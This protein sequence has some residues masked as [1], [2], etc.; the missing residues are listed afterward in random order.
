MVH[1][2]R[3]S[4]GSV[5]VYAVHARKERLKDDALVCSRRRRPIR[6]GVLKEILITD[7]D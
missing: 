4:A 5:C 7:G 2:Y 3:H 6:E 1:F